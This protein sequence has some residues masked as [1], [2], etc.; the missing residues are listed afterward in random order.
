MARRSSRPRN[1]PVA[2]EA[3]RC[4]HPVVGGD[5]HRVVAVERRGPGPGRRCPSRTRRSRTRPRA[6]GP[7]PR[8]SPTAGPTAAAPCA[9]PGCARRA[10]TRP[11]WRPRGPRPR[12]RRRA[13]RAA[14][15]GGCRP[16][17]APAGDDVPAGVDAAAQPRPTSSAAR[18]TAHPFT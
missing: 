3:R 18:A 13:G 1:R 9:G 8:S 11:R 10:R 2:G 12:A 16:A 14:P 17:T 6:R 5:T 7:G 15:D 4:Q